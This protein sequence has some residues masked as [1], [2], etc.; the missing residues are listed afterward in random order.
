[1]LRTGTFDHGDWY[2]GSARP[3]ARGRALG[4]TI[5]WGVGT[6]GTAR[7]RADV[8][9]PVRRLL[10]AAAPRLPR[11]AGVEVATGSFSGFGGASIATADFADP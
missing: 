1:M 10:H 5:A 7:D 4:E 2:S 11:G 9:R 3:G 8:A 6:D